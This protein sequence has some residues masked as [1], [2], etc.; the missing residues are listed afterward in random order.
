MGKTIIVSNRLPVKV[1]RKD[2]ELQFTPS[3]GGLA[4][5]LSTIFKSGNSRWIGWPGLY[6]KS[7]Q[8]YKTITKKLEKESMLPVFLSEDEI[9]DYYEGFSNGTLWPNFHYF[10]E[11]AIYEQPLWESY[12]AV[13]QKFAKE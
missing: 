9:R 2:D 12:V 10:T 1:L 7:D 3:E 4:T 8:E 13:N 11:F 5:G 6:T